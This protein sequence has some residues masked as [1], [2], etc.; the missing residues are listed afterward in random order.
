[1]KIKLLWVGKT[2]EP[3]LAEGV[4]FYRKRVAHYVP[5]DIEEVKGEKID[6]KSN[7]EII[8]AREADRI[9]KKLG[10]QDTV[11]ALDPTGKQFS[12]E[13][14]SRFLRKLDEEGLNTQVFVI[15]GPL[16]LGAEVLARAHTAI[17]LSKMTFTHEMARLIIMEQLY[18]A[19]TIARGEAYH[20]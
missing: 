6:A 1:M 13:A 2:K 5:V 11:F 10:P 18:R 17:S 19:L 16:G 3:F 8:K 9:L 14:F 4:E 15:G 12:S 7:P 20:K